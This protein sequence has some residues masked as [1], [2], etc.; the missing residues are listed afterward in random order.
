VRLPIH[1]I[2]TNEKEKILIIAL[3]G[4]GDALMSTPMLTLLRKAKPDAEIHVLTMFH[5]TRE[6]F[7]SN[8]NLDTIHFFDFINGSNIEGLLYLFYLRSFGFDISINI[9]PQ[10]RR[11]Y[12]IFALI[13]GAS[14]RIGLHYGHSNWQ[15]LSW[16]LT[17][18]IHENDRYH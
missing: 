18:T 3:P 13:I 16:L 14:K 4:I 8:P 10:N 17:D 12:N 5:A 7:L 9:Y 15:N 1:K 2:V 11:E 6:L